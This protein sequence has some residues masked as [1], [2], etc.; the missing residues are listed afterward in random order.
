MKNA[1]TN[2]T[3]SVGGYFLASTGMNHYAYTTQDGRKL[4]YTRGEI[5]HLRGLSDDGI[6]G[7]SPL[8]LGR[9]SIGEGLAMQAYSSRFFGNDARP[10]GWIE[11]PGQW[12]DEDT[13]RK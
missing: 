12:K 5:W 6:M 11:N 1:A 3:M 2:K 9:E 4:Y 10:P 8:E 7:L 13:K